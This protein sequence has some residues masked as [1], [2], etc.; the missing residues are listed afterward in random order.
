MKT[1]LYVTDF[2]YEAK[3]RKYY[4][5]DLFITSH[6]KE[7]FNILIG[8]PHQVLN[9]LDMAD[10]LV[11][12]NT[13]SVIGYQEYFNRFVT[14]AKEK[15]ILTF[16]SFDGKADIKGKQ[17]LLDLMDLDYPVIP[18]IDTLE[19][20]NKLGDPSTFVLK[21]KNGADSIG[22]EFLTMEEV[23]KIDV[24]GRLIQPYLDFE[25][26]VSFYYLNNSFQYALYAPNKDKRWDLIAYEATK[27]DLV[28][29]EKFVHWNEMERGIVRIDACRLKNNSLLLVEVEDLNP[30]LSL[31]AL[32]EPKRNTFLENFITVLKKL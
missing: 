26:E 1:I 5:E 27:D 16:N 4:E 24:K 25:Y 28:F 13:G 31:D 23:Q 11:F 32:S 20:L 29:A 7:H 21:L 30:F 6:L 18:T 19:D 14:I 8:H 2:Y 17:Y 3:G 22:M 9:Y 10:M 12:R 15:N